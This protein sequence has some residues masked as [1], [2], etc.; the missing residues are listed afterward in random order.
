MRL[1]ARTNLRACTHII[2][3]SPRQNLFR[4]RSLMLRLMYIVSLVI[5]DI[6]FTARYE[7]NVRIQFSIISVF[8]RR[9]LKIFTFCLFYFKRYIQTNSRQTQPWIASSVCTHLRMISVQRPACLYCNVTIAK[10]QEFKRNAIISTSLISCLMQPVEKAG[11]TRWVMNP[12]L[13]TTLFLQLLVIWKYKYVNWK[14]QSLRYI[15]QWVVRYL[16][17]LYQLH[18]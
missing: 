17:T 14:P 8:K 7:I 3:A 11:R 5:K 10:T 2:L 16:T 9:S 15:I 18:I 6:T 4:E 13:A 12:I 1:H